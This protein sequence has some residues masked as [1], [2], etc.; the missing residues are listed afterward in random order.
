MASEEEIKSLK[1]FIKECPVGELSLLLKGK[2]IF[3][4][5]DIEELKGNRE[6]LHNNEI[7]E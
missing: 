7:L 2:L 4:F 6:F 5:S 3:N 1:Y